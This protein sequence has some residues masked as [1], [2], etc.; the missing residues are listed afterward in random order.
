MEPPKFPANGLALLRH[1]LQA[2]FDAADWMS[3]AEWAPSAKAAKQIAPPLLQASH[4]G[5]ADAERF[6]HGL[7]LAALD[8]IGRE[9]SDPDLTPERIARLG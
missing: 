4:E 1:R 7:Y 8:M 2:T 3:L 6:A 9:C 5:T